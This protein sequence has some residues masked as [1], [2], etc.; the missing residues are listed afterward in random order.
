MEVHADQWQGW[1]KSVRGE[2]DCKA[3]NAK[4]LVILDGIS[5]DWNILFH[6]DKNKFSTAYGLVRIICARCKGD[7]LYLTAYIQLLT[8]L[9]CSHPIYPFK[10]TI[11][12][13]F[14]AE[15]YL[16]AAGQFSFSEVLHSRPILSI[17]LRTHQIQLLTLELKLV[18]FHTRS[19]I[20]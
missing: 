11:T 20:V 5:T 12:Y 9:T 14:S 7:R 8:I 1:E 19:R 16:Q 10:C 4:Y 15:N 6:P 3:T 13:K 17:F 18:L 2:E